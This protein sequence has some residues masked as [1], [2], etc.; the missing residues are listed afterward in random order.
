MYFI[1]IENSFIYNMLYRA[2]S[3]DRLNLGVYTSNLKNDSLEFFEFQFSEPSQDNRR[4]QTWFDINS[5]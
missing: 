5:V 2:S 3:G 1:N 4:Q